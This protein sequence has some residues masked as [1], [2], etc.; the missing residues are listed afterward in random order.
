MAYAHLA[1]KPGRRRAWA[2]GSQL[3]N[4]EVAPWVYSLALA[5]WASS[6]NLRL[7]IL[8]AWLPIE[9]TWFASGIVALCVVHRFGQP[10]RVQP[11]ALW[12]LALLCVG[13]LPGALRS[14]G[15]GYGPSKLAAM[16]FILLP[17][18][19][20]ATLLLDSREARRTWLWAQVIVGVAV[21]AA[22]LRFSDPTSLLEPGR[23]T[24]PTVDTIWAARLVGAA[25]VV[26]LLVGLAV[27]RRLRWTLP[28]AALAGIVLIRIGS[29]GPFLFVLVAIALV[30]LVGGCFARRRAW[31]LLAAGAVAVLSF[32]Y[33]AAQGGSGGKRIA[34]S[35]QSGFTDPVRSRLVQD[36]FRL[37]EGNP[38]GVGWGDF[39]QNSFVGNQLANANGDSYAH[40]LAAEAFSE[41]GLLAL[42]CVLVVVLVGLLRLKR[43][44]HDPYEAA[45]LGAMLFWVLNAQVSSDVVGNRFMWITLASALSA[46]ADGNVRRADGLFRRTFNKDT[47]RSTER[48]SGIHVHARDGGE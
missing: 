10:V 36:A 31:L 23:Y 38:L 2:V 7:S 11:A 22:T 46:F 40:N 30:L 21:T 4:A 32:L 42:I 47:A 41:G 45:L 20:A 33:A 15:D 18:V 6:W 26:L 48:D 34:G 9:P 29:R 3:R 13:F 27:P 16:L 1:V 8:M 5:F 17:V 25:I 28:L 35:L 37:G 24:L 43:L 12:P 39:A 19:C 14:S 44:S